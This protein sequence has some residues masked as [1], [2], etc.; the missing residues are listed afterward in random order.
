MTFHLLHRHSAMATVIARFLLVRRTCSNAAV[1]LALCSGAALPCTAADGTPVAAK[2]SLTVT[3]TTARAQ[4]WPV[5]LACSGAVAAWMEATIGARITGLPLVE[6]RV[7]V[8]DR[9]RKGDVLARFDDRTVLAELDLQ[10]AG[11]ALAEAAFAQADANRARIESIRDSGAVSAQDVL[12]AV[13]TAATAKAQVAQAQAQVATTRLRLGF[14]EV[15]APDDG[16]ISAR[17]A[18]IGSVS[19]AAGSGA[20][21][22]RLIRGGRLE[23][24]AELP[25]AQLASLP[26]G[27]MAHVTLP[28]GTVTRGRVRQRAPTLDSNTRL[29]LAYVD[30]EPG[31]H[32]LPAMYLNGTFDLT[33]RKAITV[34]AES[35]VIRDGRSYVVAVDGSA[36]SHLR[37]VSTGRRQQDEIEVTEGVQAG[38]RVVVKGAGFLNDNDLVRI[39]Q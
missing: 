23:W 39:A 34:P 17:G 31:S 2:P 4:S 15:V 35:V 1:A 20:E 38:D 26:I 25:A 36:R 5:P 21:L 8:G 32:A 16:I 3:L 19:Q 10:Q 33:A 29:G 13:T 37:A 7:N 6:V 30:L 12:Q 27:T 11:L 14:T 28:D 22:F 18:T 24:R 9:V